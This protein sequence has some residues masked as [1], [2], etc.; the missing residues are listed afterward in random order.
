MAISSIPRLVGDSFGKHYS[1]RQLAEFIRNKHSQSDSKRGSYK[2]HLDNCSVCWEIWNRVRWDSAWTE[3]GVQ[4]LVEYLGSD[5]E[6]YFDSS[7]ALAYEWYSQDP[8]SKKN[9]EAFYHRTKYY[10]YNSVLFYESGD[11]PDFKGVLNKLVKTYSIKS[12]LDFGCGVGNDGLDMLDIGLSVF[13][14]DLQSPSTE[15]L[16]WRLKKRNYD[17]EKARYIPISSKVV[18]PKVDMVWTID[19]L[20]HMVEP[21]EALETISQKTKL[22]VYFTDGDDK[23]GGRHPFH[24]HTKDFAIDPSLKKLGFDRIKEGKLSIWYRK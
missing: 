19:V 23:A 8:I 1:Y 20:E 12:V 13:F 14:A 9:I 3:K 16:Q 7:W 21:L 24:L 18:F 2:K 15:F 17:S 10:V 4:E 6:K 22:F 5:F 11:R